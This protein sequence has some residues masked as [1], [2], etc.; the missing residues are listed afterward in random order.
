MIAPVAS[1]ATG[2]D[3]R[4]EEATRALEA[5]LLKQ[6]VKAS[7]AFTGGDS[8][9]SA[10]R[11]DL[12][13]DALADA[14]AASG[15]LGVADAIT[16][17]LQPGGE[18]PPVAPAGLRSGLPGHPA[19][20]APLASP[21]PT[22]A[23]PLELPAEGSLTSGFGVRRDPLS[24]RMAPHTGIDVAAPTGAEIR[25]PVGGVVRSAGARGGYGNAVEIDHGNGLSTLYGHASELLVSPGETVAAGQAIATVG[26]TGLSTGPHVHFEVR[27]SGRPVDPSRLLKKYGLRAEGS[28]GS[29]P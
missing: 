28:H 19:A 29:G 23:E 7:N 1:G 5:M 15:G 3:P 21:A 20:P 14:V 4:L 22:F 27:V 24:G 6:I 26:S 12:F 10:V 18:P 16:R 11:A 13:A 17:S 9:G 8:A 25:A 2:A